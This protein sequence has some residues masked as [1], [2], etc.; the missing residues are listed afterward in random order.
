MV[1][2]GGHA[3]IRVVLNIW[4][5]LAGLVSVGLGAWFCPWDLLAGLTTLVLGLMLVGLGVALFQEG[6]GRGCVAVAVPSR[7]PIQRPVRFPTDHGAARTRR[8]VA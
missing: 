6:A 4:T 3:V 8:R 5:T 2:R 7:P 1:A